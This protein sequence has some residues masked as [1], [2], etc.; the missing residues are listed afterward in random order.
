MKSL[1]A[2]ALLFAPCIAAAGDKASVTLDAGGYSS[3]G[4][5]DRVDMPEV[6][7]TKGI[8]SRKHD[9]PVAEKVAALRQ[10]IAYLTLM[11]K[12][13]VDLGKKVTAKYEDIPLAKILGELLP[14]VPVKFDGVDE[15]E[16]VKSLDC[17]DAPLRSVIDWLDDAAGVYFGF[18]EEGITVR[19]A[20]PV[21]P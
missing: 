21:I 5:S 3:S 4:G 10:H 6:E 17:K 1:I 11:E 19:A 8:G 7:V 2:S 15:N 18:S 9:I 13:G 12:H 16:T 20:P 14:K